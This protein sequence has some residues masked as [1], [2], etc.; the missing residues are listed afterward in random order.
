MELPSARPR[1]LR[2]SPALRQLVAGPQ[3]APSDFVAPLFVRS[4]QHIRQE[5][6]SMPGVYQMS[7]DV[8]VDELQR[9]ADLG[10]VGP[11]LFGITESK[12]KDATGSYALNADNPVCT[13]LRLAKQNQIPM[14]LMTDL[15]FCEYTDHGH[16]GPL[17]G[18]AHQTTVD[19]DRTLAL[20]A[21]QAVLHAQCGADV[22]APSGMMDGMV[23]AIRQGL[24]Q[25][26]HDN[27]AILAYAVKYASAF[28]GPFRD[29]A[30]SPPQ[31]GD[32][33]SY[34]MDFR[35]DAR[36]ALT[37]AQLDI[38]QGADMLMVKP[39]VPYLDVLATLRQ[40]CDVPLAA[41]HVS[42]EYSMLQAAAAKNWIDL[43]GTALETMYAFK[44]AGA[45]FIITYLAGALAGWLRAK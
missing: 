8:A 4:G 41:Y 27:I 37:E 26:G 19:N 24:D 42:G 15:C 22:I 7:P 38:A 5:V 20:L 40:Q 29:A 1:R 28:Y 23:G 33:K 2:R 39:G 12:D 10:I 11:I 14:A 45:D 44:R 18:Q 3:L 35:R 34:Q 17:C 25:A 43:Q 31:F 13:T 21:K 9:L 36:E 30:E 32:R 16:C 6:T